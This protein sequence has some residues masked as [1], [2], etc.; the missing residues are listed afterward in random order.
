MKS[1]DSSA[2][3]QDDKSMVNAKSSSVIPAHAGIQVR[4]L[5]SSRIAWIP[6]LRE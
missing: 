3:A 1:L 2:Q 5:A 6:V 4:F